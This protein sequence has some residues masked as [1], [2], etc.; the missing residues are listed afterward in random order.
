MDVS[1]QFVLVIERCR[2]S[3]D[4]VQFHGRCFRLTSPVSVHDPLL[5]ACTQVT[6]YIAFT[7]LEQITR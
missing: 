6:L 5:S 1:V 3:S 4:I 2:Q 7:A